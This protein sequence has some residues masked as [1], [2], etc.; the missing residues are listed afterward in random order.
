MNKT[1]LFFLLRTAYCC[2]N[3]LVAVG[4]KPTEDED[5]HWRLMEAFASEDEEEKDETD[6]LSPK[7]RSFMMADSGPSEP[8][9]PSLLM[10]Q[11][12]KH[13]LGRGQQVSKMKSIRHDKSTGRN[14]A[15]NT[16]LRP[17]LWR[18]LYD[19][20]KARTKVKKGWERGVG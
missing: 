16:N 15:V 14:Q 10:R 20:I 19:S 8:Y 7:N 18:V 2:S 3:T 6:G 5:R 11:V 1:S 4:L 13:S 9:T 17:D 12:T